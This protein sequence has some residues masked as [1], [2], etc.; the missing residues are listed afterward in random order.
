MALEEPPPPV[1]QF[2][3][4]L[5]VGMQK[6]T[7]GLIYRH[8]YIFVGLAI[9]SI[10]IVMVHALRSS[11]DSQSESHDRD[12]IVGGKNGRIEDR[13]SPAKA[14]RSRI[15]A[16][17]GSPGDLAALA[18][19]LDKLGIDDDPEILS[20]FLSA[21]FTPE[22]SAIVINSWSNA[23]GRGKLFDRF[24]SKLID[25]GD[26]D[27]LK[28]LASNIEN[29]FLR[30]ETLSRAASNSDIF[31]PT[32][33]G[34]LIKGVDDRDKRSIGEG[35]AEK[36]LNSGPETRLQQ[37]EAYYNENEDPALLSPIARAIT[38]TLAKDNPSEAIQWALASPPT[39]VEGG[40][41]DLIVELGST[42]VNLST[43][44]AN[45]LL[46]RNEIRRASAAFREIAQ[47]CFGGRPD[48]AI[49]WA[50]KLPQSVTSRD[51]ILLQNF[52]ALYKRD[53]D[54]ARQIAD[55]LND[56]AVSAAFATAQRIHK[57]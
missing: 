40:D 55:K 23:R 18:E 53:P 7:R 28:K 57:K 39:A 29:N 26:A 20:L 34:E 2:P 8:L 54:I 52:S 48:E 38:A 46:D 15:K 24:V 17:F 41:R 6:L 32:T 56:P 42:N 3:D 14:R 50:A 30:A 12:L 37:V 27:G 4:S 51:S 13:E 31:N 45:S 35:I 10:L 19:G 11:P 43:Q 44:F 22:Q 9:V 49:E 21:D 1:N 47:N 25:L 36:I 5:I 33:I 16:S